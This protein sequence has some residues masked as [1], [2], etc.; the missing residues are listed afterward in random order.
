MTYAEAMRRFG[1]DRPDLRIPLELVDL[2]D[3]MKAVEFKVFAGPANDPEGRV[4]ALRVPGVRDQPQGYRRLH[5]VCRQLRRTRAGLHQ[6]QRRG[7]RS[8]GSAVTDPQVPARRRRRGDRRAHAV[9]DGDLVFFGADKATSS[10]ITGCAARQAGRGPR[11]GRGRLGAG[12]GGRFPDVRA[13]CEEQSL[14]GAASPVHRA[15]SR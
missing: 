3:V 4:A 7:R 5:Q 9:A 14:D 12:L 13:G 2:G 10:T 1:T 8:R 6:G 11:P 15:D